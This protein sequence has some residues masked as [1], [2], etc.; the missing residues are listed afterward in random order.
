MLS[1][2]RL[3]GVGGGGFLTFSFG[4]GGGGGA[5]EGGGTEGG[6]GG[7][8][9]DMGMRSKVA[10]LTLERGSLLNRGTL[11]PIAALRL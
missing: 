11:W 10:I 6:G 2:V 9:E 1:G 3:L 5:E 4:G 7:G 8:T